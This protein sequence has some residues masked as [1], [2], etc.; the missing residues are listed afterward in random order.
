MV[1][2]TNILA[3]SSTDALGEMEGCSL[4]IIIAACSSSGRSK[5]SCR[6]I[7]PASEP[8]LRRTTGRPVR[9]CCTIILST[10]WR[11]PGTWA[12]IGLDVITSP[13][14]AI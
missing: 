8:S 9:L 5:M 4:C 14:V 13:T 1:P 3:A 2:S 7:I 11:E 6:V 10:S 12:T